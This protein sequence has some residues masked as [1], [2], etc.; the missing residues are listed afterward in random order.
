MLAVQ[1]AYW[2]DSWLA[3]SLVAQKAVSWAVRWV[4]QTAE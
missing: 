1:M 4:A 3:V 2:M